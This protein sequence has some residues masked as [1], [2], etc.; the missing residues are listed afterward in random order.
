M[1]L[2][3][4]AHGVSPPAKDSNS[5]DM[6]YFAKLLLAAALLPCGVKADIVWVGK[7]ASPDFFE[8]ANWDFSSS[9][10]KSISANAPIA[11]HLVITDGGRITW[12]AGKI[13]LVHGKTLTV[14][15]TRLTCLGVG[16]FD[17]TVDLKEK[18]V[19]TPAVLLQQGASAQIDFITSTVV[20]V[21]GTS[22]LRLRGLLDPINSMAGAASVQ[23]TAG[24]E[25]MFA[26]KSQI[27]KQGDSVFIDGKMLKDQPECAAVEGD[28]PAILT[29]RSK[30]L[31]ESLEKQ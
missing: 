1:P 5:N 3:L 30:G 16:G 18:N 12:N 25:L 28:S 26:D 2:L 15:N 10:V 19:T 23:L 6:H 29:V 9:S 20:S 8:A 14:R 31:R 11:D 13:S 27:E 21:D 4:R 22:K 17:R 24:A 7:G